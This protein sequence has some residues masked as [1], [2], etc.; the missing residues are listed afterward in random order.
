MTMTSAEYKEEWLFSNALVAF[1]GALMLTQQWQVSEGAVTFFFI[2]ELPEAVGYAIFLVIAGFFALSFFL[3]VASVIPV[4]RNVALLIGKKV[5][6]ALDFVIWIGIH[7][8]LGI[9]NH[10]AIPRSVVGGDAAV[11]R[12][13]PD[14]LHAGEDGAEARAV[15]GRIGVLCFCVI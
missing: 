14:R 10:P 15:I 4:L 8:E 5:S 6:F 9:G 2:L 12:P 13:S 3:A 7:P 11:G 1:V